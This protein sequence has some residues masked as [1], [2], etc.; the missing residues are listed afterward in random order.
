MFVGCLRDPAGY[1]ITDGIAKYVCPDAGLAAK[2]HFPE[3][4]QSVTWHS[5]RRNPV[6]TDFAP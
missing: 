4:I 6:R 1:G 5:L 3:A 2:L